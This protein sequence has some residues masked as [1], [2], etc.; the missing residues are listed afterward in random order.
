MTESIFI[1]KRIFFQQ[2]AKS[3]SDDNVGLRVV[4]FT[5]KRKL[6]DRLKNL[7]VL[8]RCTRNN[9]INYTLQPRKQLAMAAANKFR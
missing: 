7:N 6:S 4:T 9:V 5:I 3:R 8:M 1:K 2:H